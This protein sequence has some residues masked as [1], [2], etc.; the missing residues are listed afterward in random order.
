MNET[1]KKSPRRRRR[2]RRPAVVHMGDERAVEKS[3]P[4]PPPKPARPQPP[5][6]PPRERRGGNAP[7]R[8]E[9]PQ[10]D[11]AVPKV[12]MREAE[13]MEVSPLDPDVFIYTYTLYP[14]SL[15]DSYQPAPNITDR[16][17]YT[18]TSD[19]DEEPPLVAG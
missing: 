1:P 14:R 11:A 18:H 6:N 3:P 10:R 8:P 12:V 4:P 2:P 13:N 16:M 15:L 17:R 5:A 7:S 9:R 19:A